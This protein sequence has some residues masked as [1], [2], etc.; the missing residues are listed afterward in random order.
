MFNEA[1]ISP[2]IFKD[3]KISRQTPAL[4]ISVNAPKIS[5]IPERLIYITVERTQ[6][7]EMSGMK[8]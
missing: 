2:R 4:E 1:I 3:R 5:P 7:S 8:Y 6:I